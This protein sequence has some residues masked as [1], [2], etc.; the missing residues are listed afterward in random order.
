[1]DDTIAMTINPIDKGT[2]RLSVTELKMV[3]V[4]IFKKSTSAEENIKAKLRNIAMPNEL[5][6]KTNAPFFNNFILILILF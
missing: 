2:M 1:M 3:F 5:I 4:F 6:G